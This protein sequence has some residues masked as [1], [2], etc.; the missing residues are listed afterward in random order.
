MKGR[1]T[2]EI[3][4]DYFQQVVPDGIVGKNKEIGF[5]DKLI[6]LIW[7]LFT[8]LAIKIFDFG[9]QYFIIKNILNLQASYIKMDEAEIR[10]ALEQKQ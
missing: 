6:Q 10:E 3:I 7:V 9:N 1:I 4:Q 8:K 5:S 2:R